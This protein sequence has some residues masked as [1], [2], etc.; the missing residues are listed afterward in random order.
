[1]VGVGCEKAAEPAVVWCLGDDREP[2]GMVVDIDDVIQVAAA[3]VETPGEEVTDDLYRQGVIDLAA[4]LCS[5]S[6]R[7]TEEAKKVMGYAICGVYHPV[8]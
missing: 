7:T 5:P 6:G 2:V 3:L 8:R 1:M 4:A